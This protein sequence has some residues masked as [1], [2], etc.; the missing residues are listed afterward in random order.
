MSLGTLY[1]DSQG[2]WERGEIMPKGV[3][4]GGEWLGGFASEGYLLV[5]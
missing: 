4:W 5:T 3:G 2:Y 1:R